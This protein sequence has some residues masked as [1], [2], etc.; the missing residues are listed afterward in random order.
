M[1]QI[2]FE[3]PNGKEEG[4]VLLGPWRGNSSRPTGSFRYPSSKYSSLETASKKEGKM[5][6]TNPSTLVGG[7][8]SGEYQRKRVK[9]LENQIEHFIRILDSVPAMIFFKDK[10]GRNLFAN[11]TLA[12]ALGKS[13]EEIVGKTTAELFPD[14]AEEM[15]RNDTE[16][17]S[18]GKAK[19][20][21]IETY[22]T[23]NGRRWASTSK[24]PYLDES[25]NIQG[26]VGFALDITELMDARERLKESELIKDATLDGMSELVAYYDTELR[27]KYANRAVAE[28]AD[29]NAG[30]LVGRHCYEIWGYRGEPCEGC[31]VLKAIETG[32][33]QSAEVATP[34]GKIWLVRGSP[35]FDKHGEVSG[36]VGVTLEIT[37][38]K[39]A[40]ERLRDSV[41]EK[42][43]LL[44][45][46]HH[47]VKNNLQ[48]MS[49][50]LRIQGRLVKHKRLEGILKESQNRI[51]TMS[52]VHE[53][54][55]RSKDLSR[56]DFGDYLR[57]L[58][59]H[60]LNAYES[61]GKINLKIDARPIKIGVD[62]AI[63]CGLIANELISNALKHAFP[64]NTGG[65][66]KVEFRSL[67]RGW[68]KMSLGDNGV[69][70]PGN[71]NPEDS[72]SPGFHLVNMLARD[73]LRGEIEVDRSGGTRVT[74]RFRRR[75]K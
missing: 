56:I 30:D 9:E 4:L 3:Q 35:V 39:R 73:Q 65:E 5:V 71:I 12:D 54:L 2:C 32:F 52:L 22:D 23:P 33:S 72:E 40:E 63:P 57:V 17:I 58:S 75:A 55:Y 36:A 14:Q 10:E 41:R 28:S 6:L 18:S 61:R 51:R 70:I 11:Q 21:I 24:I 31:P 64:G 25:V 49:S 37:S 68:I 67:G 8:K 50:L 42:E 43:I 46:V 45:E 16:V 69:G 62:Y 29:V 60:L 1:L 19:R 66:V 34:D 7:K 13:K 26:V 27:I 53:K 20:G 59:N 74:V 47:R 15:F 44:K 38:I 48:V